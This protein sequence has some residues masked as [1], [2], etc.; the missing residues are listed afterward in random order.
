M[1]GK[2]FQRPVSNTLDFIQKYVPTNAHFAK[3]PLFVKTVVTFNFI[4]FSKKK[5]G[6]LW[7]YKHI[8]RKV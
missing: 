8:L 1:S 5:N 7:K 3:N 4:Y 2:Q 6:L